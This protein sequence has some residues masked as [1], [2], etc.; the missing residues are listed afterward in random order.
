MFV[1]LKPV[2][3]IK[4]DFGTERFGMAKKHT[5][6]LSML[7]AV[8]RGMSYEFFIMMLSSTFAACSA[9]SQQASRRSKMSVQTIT[10]KGSL[11]PV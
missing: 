6:H 3:H 5:E 4:T 9:A 11:F 8:I 1:M 2:S 10:F 7:R